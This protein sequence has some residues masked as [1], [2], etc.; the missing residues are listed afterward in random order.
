MRLIRTLLLFAVAGIVAVFAYNYWSSGEWTLAP[1]NAVGIDAEKAGQ[2]AAELANVAVA[3]ASDTAVKLEGAMSEGT[4]TAK[5]KSKMAL[6]D[7][8]KAR[9]INVDTSDSVV[10]LTGIVASVQERDRAVRLARETEG[11]TN[12]RRAI[13]AFVAAYGPTAKPFIWRK[14]EAKGSQLRN[15]IVN[16]C[17]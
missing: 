14:R 11:V 8:V 5:I 10:T 17:N 13:E 6:D 3:K 15:T 12:V 4:L 7:Y 1:R 16:L 2:R 9:T